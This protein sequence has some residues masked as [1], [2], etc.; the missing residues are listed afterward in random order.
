M[1]INKNN[2]SLLR[3]DYNREMFVMMGDFDETTPIYNFDGATTAQ[4]DAAWSE[5]TI[6][7]IKNF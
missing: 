3:S 5:D 2:V 1:I 6:S 7:F 4:W